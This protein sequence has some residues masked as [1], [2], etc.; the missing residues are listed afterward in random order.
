MI[1]VGIRSTVAVIPRLP[2]ADHTYGVDNRFFAGEVGQLLWTGHAA[3]LLVGSQHVDMC[4][5]ERASFQNQAPTLQ[6]SR[7]NVGPCRPG[8]LHALR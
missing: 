1:Y 6:V 8:N 3:Q 5:A 7:A 2:P 4:S